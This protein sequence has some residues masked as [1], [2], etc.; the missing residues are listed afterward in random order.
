MLASGS[1]PPVRGTVTVDAYH[2]AVQRFIPARAGNSQPLP[3]KYQPKTVHPRPCGE[4]GGWWYSQ[5][6]TDGSSPPVRGTV[7]QIDPFATLHRFI[8]A[9]AGNR[10]AAMQITCKAAVHPRPCGEQ[11]CRAPIRSTGRGSSPPV[12]GTVC[13]ERP[14]QSTLRFIPARAGNR[15]PGATC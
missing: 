4:Q 5:P 13:S 7:N 2:V 11:W 10:R 9:R 1:S 12:R 14:S 15:E 3:R 8:P 6:R